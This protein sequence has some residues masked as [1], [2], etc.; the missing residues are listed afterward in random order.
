LNHEFIHPERF[1]GFIALLYHISRH[2]FTTA[3]DNHPCTSAPQSR[4][5]AIAQRHQ[6][7]DPDDD[8]VL[9]YEWSV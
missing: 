3:S 2:L 1:G 5:K 6:R 7:I 4:L 8:L 9:I